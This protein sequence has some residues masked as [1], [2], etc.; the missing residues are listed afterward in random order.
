MSEPLSPS[1]PFP[2]SRHSGGPAVLED[3]PIS[4]RGFLGF[5][6]AGLCLISGASLL[7]T[8]KPAH[9]IPLS[10]KGLIGTRIS[11]WFTPLEGRVVRCELCPRTC[12]VKDGKR[13]HCRVRENR[14]GKYYSLVYGNPCVVYMDPIEKKPLYHVLPSTW[15]FSIATAG[16]NFSCK[17]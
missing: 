15:C 5:C 13:G 12:R 8:A 6:G 7:T 2:V 14:G 4:R 16:C 11:P 10:K 3:R 9:A 1:F 17:F